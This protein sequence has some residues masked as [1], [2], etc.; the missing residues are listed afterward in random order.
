MAM[1]DLGVILEVQ[2]HRILYDNANPFY[3]DNYRKEQAW[4]EVSAALRADPNDCKSRWRMLRDSYVKYLKK[5]AASNCPPGGAQRD[6][7]FSNSMSFILPFVQNR[8]PKR[9]FLASSDAECDR[10]C[11]PSSLDPSPGPGLPAA[12]ASPL[13]PWTAPLEEERQDRPSVTEGDREEMHHFA[14]STV[15]QLLR[16]GKRQR[17][18]AKIEMLQLLDRLEDEEE[19]HAAARRYFYPNAP[20][21]S[22]AEAAAGE[23]PRPLQ[24]RSPDEEEHL[25]LRCQ[26]NVLLRELREDEARFTDFFSLSTAQFDE[27][28]RR[29]G[30]SITLQDT[31]YR[32]PIPAAVRLGV[33]LRYLASGDPLKLVADSFGVAQSSVCKILPQVAAALWD[34]LRGEVLAEP[35]LADWSLMA[36]EFE[37]LWDFPCAAGR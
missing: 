19:Q 31:N 14:L 34:S 4:S 29:V 17:R 22:R 28:L 7:K 16:L 12:P 30:N 36:E 2:K 1:D 13:P 5:A 8:A 27:L 10:P 6:W 9:R 25:L 33:C 26:D 24:G 23:P 37:R 3:K 35:S 32:R 21:S 11:P 20:E 18:R 15:P